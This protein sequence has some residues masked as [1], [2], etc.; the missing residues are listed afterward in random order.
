MKVTHT[1]LDVYREAVSL[2]RD[3]EVSPYLEEV[4]ANTLQSMSL[5]TPGLQGLEPGACVA[6]AS[7]G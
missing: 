6:I 2:Y 4:I 7:R 5:V 3:E 1:Y